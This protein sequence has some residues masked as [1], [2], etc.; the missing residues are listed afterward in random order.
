MLYASVEDILPDYDGVR[1][2]W[3]WKGANSLRPVIRSANCFKK[4]SGL[5]HRLGAV[6]IT[7]HDPEKIIERT[8][9]DY[10]FDVDL[11]LAAGASH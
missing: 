2:G 8:D 4:G 6:E 11:V 5:A 7:D 9:S 10:E 3:D 1:I